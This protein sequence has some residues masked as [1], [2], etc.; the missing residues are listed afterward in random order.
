MQNL[1]LHYLHRDSG[2]YKT[3]GEVIFANP[4]NLTAEEAQ[5]RF[6]EQLIATEFFYCA[7]WNLPPLMPPEGEWYEFVKFSPTIE[8]ITDKRTLEEFLKGSDSESQRR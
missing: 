4:G 7:D 3:F 6:C 8:A 1:K 5:K 2:N